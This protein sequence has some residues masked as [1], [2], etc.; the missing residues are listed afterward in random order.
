MARYINKKNVD[1]AT[2]I[3]E[4]F[5]KYVK[6]CRRISKQLN[7]AVVIGSREKIQDAKFG[8]LVAPLKPNLKV[9]I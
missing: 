1:A 5:S 8:Y 4:S 9:R 3:D 7:K 2:T 6:E